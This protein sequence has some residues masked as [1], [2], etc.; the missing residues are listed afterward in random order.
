MWLPLRFALREMRGGPARLLRLHRL[1]R[2]RHRW[3]SRASVRSPR[4]S[5][6]GWRSKGRVIL[7]GDISFLADAARSDAAGTGLPARARHAFRARRPCAR[8]RGCR[9]AA[10]AWSRSRRWTSA[11]RCSGKSKLDPAMPLDRALERAATASI[12]AAVDP[13]LMARFDLKP[14]DRSAIGEAQFELRAA[15]TNEP[16]KLTIGI[17]FGPRAAHQPFRRCARP[18]CSSPAAWCIGSTAF[19]CRKAPP[20]TRR[21]RSPIRHVQ[22]FPQAGWQIR[23]RK[24]A[25]PADRARRRPLYAISD[26][27]RADGAARRWC[28]RR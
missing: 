10:R 16:D 22:Q 18:A 8:W 17:G 28:G 11:T 19:A 24:R 27:R 13:V 25:T 9:T 14:G 20:R 6:T 5:P 2:A 7:G 21:S 3:R 12:G 1:H 15:L 26:H 23:T 4:A